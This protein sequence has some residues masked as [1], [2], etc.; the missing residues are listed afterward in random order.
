MFVILLRLF[1]W[2]GYCLGQLLHQLSLSSV[3]SKLGHSCQQMILKKHKILKEPKPEGWNIL[4]MLCEK[5]IAWF[6]ENTVCSTQRQGLSFFFIIISY[7]FSSAKPLSFIPFP[8][9]KTAQLKGVRIH[10]C[11]T[12]LPSKY[13]TIS[14]RILR[15]WNISLN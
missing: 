5:C 2:P 9:R 13:V 11:C 8:L 12:Q 3:L 10:A 7:L 1:R 6:E 4:H 14:N 15:R